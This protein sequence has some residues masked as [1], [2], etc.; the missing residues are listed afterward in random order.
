M[1]CPTGGDSGRTYS[2]QKQQ[3][4]QAPQKEMRL[5]TENQTRT[6]TGWWVWLMLPAALG[7][8][9]GLEA[10]RPFEGETV[11]RVAVVGHETT[12]EYV[13]LRELSTR[14]GEPFH[15]G[16][17]QADVQ[18]LDNLDIFSSV[19]VTGAEEGGGVA[20]IYR[21]RE[22]PYMLPYITYDVT[23]QDGW[24]FGP[25]VKSVNML[26]KDIFVAGYALFGGRTSF[27]LDSSYPWVAG[28]HVS[29]DLD[30]YRIQRQNDLDG[31]GETAFEFT[32]RLGTYLGDRG[33]AAVGF[34]Y[35]KVESDTDGHTLGADNVDVLYRVTA[36][37]GYD[38]RDAWGDP[39][40]GWL[41][42][43]ELTQTG[44]ILPG[45]GDFYTGHFDVRRFQPVGRHTLAV[46]GLLTL[47]GGRLGLSVPEY[48]DY[49]LGGSNSIRGYQL[50]DLGQWLHGR[51]Q[52][53]GTVEYRVPLAA[54]REVELLGL[55]ADL[56]LAGALFVDSGAAWDR[57]GQLSRNR[58]RTGAG[59]G[60]RLLMPAVDMTRLDL[61]FGQGGNWG[62][63]FAVFS[64]F[65]AQ[66]LRLR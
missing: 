31:F 17:V 12:R 38:S 63:H 46:G 48:L 43:V 9:Q 58:F 27:L 7:A 50:D 42:E 19:S 21:V 34:T 14:V 62:I 60:L 18:R 40:R 52:F 41:N 28:N 51:N 13:I 22:L 45:D 44:G 24:S 66:R 1:I 8:D 32:P 15:A 39:H 61:A 6:W 56:G 65:R 23:D 30:L 20:I 53:L 11:V 4:Y 47:Q 2:L 37:L 49:H 29:L 59:V 55:A 25:A 36:S 26:G 3:T 5:R 16:T 35:L 54:A 10:L 64:K 33:R 57:R